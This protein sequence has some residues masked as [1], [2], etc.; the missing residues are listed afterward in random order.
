[1]RIVLATFLVLLI[2]CGGA[3]PV[4]FAGIKD[5]SFK[6]ED[7]KLPPRPDE[8]PIPAGK[9]WVVPLAKDKLA[10]KDGVLISA[11]K[12]VRAAKYKERYNE[13]RSLYDLDRHVWRS[14]RVIQEAQRKQA[15]QVIKDLTPSWWQRNKGVLGWTSGTVIGAAMTILV[16]YGVDKVQEN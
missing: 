2:G 6:V 9:D 4:H 11:E 12:A 10:P 3:V 5:P 1:M 7:R 8:K 15:N 14:T 13:I 16:V